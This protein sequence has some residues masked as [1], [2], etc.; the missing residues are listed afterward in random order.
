MTGIADFIIAVAN[1]IEAE[2]RTLRRSVMRMAL[3]VLLFVL[4]LAFLAAGIGLLTW[5]VYLLFLEAVGLPLAAFLSGIVVL[6][7]AGILVGVAILLN[8]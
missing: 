1:L 3:G 5:C 6:I 4:G 7:A 8:R 2:G